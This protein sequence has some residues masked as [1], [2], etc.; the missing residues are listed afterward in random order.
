MLNIGEDAFWSQLI[1]LNRRL[2][3]PGKK[4]EKKIANE[5]SNGIKYDIIDIHSA[6]GVAKYECHDEL[7]KFKTTTDG[8]NSRNGMFWFNTKNKGHEKTK[9]DREQDIP[10]N[11]FDTIFWHLLKT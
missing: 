10:K 5:R 11:I 6:E 1:F 7:G 3:Q 9:R 2:V 4:L 8:K